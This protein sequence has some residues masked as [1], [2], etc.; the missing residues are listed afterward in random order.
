MDTQRLHRSDAPDFMPG[1]LFPLT[2]LTAREREVIALV[3]AGLTNAQIAR[4]LNVQLQTLKKALS[5][6]YDKVG[7]S[8]RLQLA[9]LLLRDEVRFGAAPLSTQAFRAPAPAESRGAACT[10]LPP[11]ALSRI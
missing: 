6:I 4:R 8:T 10:L 5:A 11:P 3:L 9:V 7:V 1:D 2:M